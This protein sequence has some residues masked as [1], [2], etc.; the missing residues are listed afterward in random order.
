[1]MEIKVVRKVLSVNERMAEQNRRLF[2]EKG[3]YV[4]NIMSSPGSGK[5]ALLEKTLSRIAAD[6][7]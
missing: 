4:I 3:V 1:M 2:S 6:I 5:T 7:P